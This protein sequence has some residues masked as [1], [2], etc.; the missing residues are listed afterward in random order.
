MASDNLFDGL[1][2][3]VFS[4]V[5]ATMGYTAVW[6]PSDGSPLQTSRVLFKNPTEHQKLADQ[7]YDPYRYIMEF[8]RG[9]F[10]GLKQS[11]DANKVE[12]VTIGA[13]NYYVR[14]VNGKYDGG[15]MVA[16]LELKQ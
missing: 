14:Q 2:N 9:V 10:E 16:T 8:K 13:A 15:T 6:Q 5:T 1:G 4:V 11:V 12:E 7:E 3:S